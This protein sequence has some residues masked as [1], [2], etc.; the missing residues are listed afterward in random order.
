MTAV[1]DKIMRGYLLGELSETEQARVEELLFS[2]SD[3]HD[4]LRALKAEIT[5]QYV[6]GTLPATQRERFARRFL[7]DENGREDLLFARAL[8]GVIREQNTVPA[9]APQP[10]PAPS[11]RDSL[12]AFFHSLADWQMA[13]M[14]MTAA[15][16]LLTLGGAWLFVETLRL[17][18]QLETAARERDAARDAAARD[19]Q[20]SQ[21]LQDELGRASTR[22]QELD[23][24]AREAAR[25]RDAA[26]QELSQLRQ[27]PSSG[28]VFGAL[29]SLLL[30]PG[31]G[32]GSANIEQLRLTPQ[33][34]TAQLQLLIA[35]GEEKP[36]YRAEVRN[37]QDVVI[38]TQNQFRTRRTALGRALLV[39]VPADKL[40]E[41]E[42]TVRL[43][44]VTPGQAPELLNFYDFKITRR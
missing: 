7:R 13:P 23:Q 18:T 5:D 32:R 12:A 36:G 1:D 26:R 30:A 29:L 42:Y 33:A 17:R 15:M 9:P 38:Y 25:E 44:G 3:G 31:A 10:E 41:G 16:V 22:N 43:S 4:R 24:Q 6:R 28:P 40:P 27:P 21:R 2:D 11:W 19:A 37:K 8:D 35:A 39:N 14:V 20:A 34:R